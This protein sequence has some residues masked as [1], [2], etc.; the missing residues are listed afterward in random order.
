MA[1]RCRPRLSLARRQFI[2]ALA[3]GLAGEVLAGCGTAPSTGSSS[4]NVVLFYSDD[5]GY[6]DFGI[7]GSPDIPTPNIDSIGLGGVRFTSGYVSAPVCSPSRA[8]LLTGRYQARFGHE[9]N[10]DAK[11]RGLPASETTLAEVLSARGYATALIGKWHLGR[12]E[13]SHPLDN[14]FS[15]F[16]GTL[17]YAGSHRPEKE[18]RELFYIR[19]RRTERSARSRPEAYTAESVSFI[20]RRGNGPFFL[21]L[22]WDVPHWPIQMFPEYESRVRHIADSQRRKYATM[23]V[24]MDEGV[25]RVLAAVRRAGVEDRT[26]VFFINDNGARAD[27]G[28]GRARSNGPLRGGKGMLFEGGIRVVFLWRWPG[29]IPAGL[30]F[31][32]PVIALDVFPTV[33]AAAGVVET[34][35]T[36]DGVD[37]LPYVTGERGGP[38]HDMLAWRACDQPRFATI[39]MGD[40]KLHVNGQDSFMLFNLSDDLGEAHDVAAAH[41]DIVERLRQR[42]RAWDREVSAEAAA[43]ADR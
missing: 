20:E 11:E 27:H 2:Q 40:W 34:R 32:Y 6:V 23:M 3:A 19:G 5:A 13:L 17:Q 35:T 21:Y 15:E 39:R 8:G 22:P 4:P 30:T 43:R 37:L 41:P 24:A 10:E 25:G 38:P 7:Q 1:G 31:P 28:P 12:Q 36:L 9:C 14:G 33:A 16:F 42:L 26:L 29:R 18:E